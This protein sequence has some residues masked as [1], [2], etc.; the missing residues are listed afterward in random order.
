M[1]VRS[2]SAVG[3]PGLGP[4]RRS[5]VSVHIRPAVGVLGLLGPGMVGLSC[6]LCL[7]APSQAYS[8]AN[9]AVSD[10]KNEGGDGVALVS[11]SILW[12]RRLVPIATCVYVRS[13]SAQASSR[14]WE[15]VGHNFAD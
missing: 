8:S 4:R 14:P 13:C 5:I 11:T 9:L 12:E 3:R 1:H 15:E 6:S 10:W 7:R 2:E